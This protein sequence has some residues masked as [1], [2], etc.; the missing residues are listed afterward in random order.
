MKAPIAALFLIA[1]FSPVAIAQQTPYNCSAPGHHRDFDFWLGQWEV[2]DKAGKLQG[3]NHITARQKGCLLDEQWRSV[4][5]GTGQS[6]NYYNPVTQQWQQL[7]VDAGASV[8]DI[9]GGLE[10]GSMV[11]TGT[12]F[13][14]KT[15]LKK[16]FRGRWTPLPDG[17]VQQFFE[18]QN[19]DG[20]WQTWFDGY[21]TRVTTD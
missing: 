12:V 21:Y 8:I 6:I 7:W 3:H 18:E 1:L 2:H 13:Y 11:L 17:R 5:G 16:E 4:K 19:K 9:G 15:S 14:L 10:G 20:E